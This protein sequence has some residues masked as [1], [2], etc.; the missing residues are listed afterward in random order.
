MVG[1]IGQIIRRGPSTW[2]VRIYVG[3]DSETKN[4]KY[5]SKTIHGVL[6]VAQAQL[7]RLLAER[8]LCFL[9]QTTVHSRQRLEM[10]G[11]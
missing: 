11:L 10:I 1:K 6:R 9:A 3:R 8:Y 2:L 5:I 7:N 4:R